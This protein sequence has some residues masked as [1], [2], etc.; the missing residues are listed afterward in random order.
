MPH[1]YPAVRYG[2]PI[3]SVQG[4][5]AATAALGHEVHVYTTN[6]DGSG[7]CDVPIGV[8]VS[9]NGVAVWYFAAGYGKK[10]FRSPAM[11]RVLDETIASFDVVH[12]HYVWVWTT[13]RTAS[14]ARRHAVPYV[15]APRG[16]LVADLIRRRSS[17]AK[18][19]WLALFDRRNV[20]G[21]AAIH[22][23]SE[24][25]AEEFRALGLASR[26]VVVIP[27]G[28]DLPD[29][30]AMSAHTSSCERIRQPYF[31]FL[32]RISWKKGLDRLVPALAQV[33]GVDL[34]IAGHDENGYRANIERLAVEAGVEAR[35]RFLGPVEDREK[36]A[37]I[38][39]AQCLVLPSY[40]ENFGMAV[41]EAMAVGCPV[42]VTP[43]VGVADIIAQ[44]CSGVVAE[45]GSAGLAAALRSVIRDPERARRMGQAGRR[46]ACE[47][48][49]WRGIAGRI[50][51]LYRECSE[52]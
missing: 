50:V 47:R 22:A 20:A 2:G 5:A 26:R 45:G 52:T 38:R 34:L 28:V 9:L 12:I 14:A 19:A 27:N 30:V 31:L 49:V 3:R 43:E 8:P 1:Y 17:L 42:V 18:R 4:L 7:V 40:N 51:E 10:V 15:L 21:A 44:T 36:W 16:M 6:V 25:E 35:T 24:I 29:E 13:I 11:G 32:G 41:V 48:F 37:L 33:Q 46:V 23:T 39:G